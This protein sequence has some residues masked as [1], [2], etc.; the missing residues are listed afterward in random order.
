MPVLELRGVSKVVEGR[1]VLRGVDL[2]VGE[3]DVVLL[4]GPNGSGKTTLI[5]VAVGLLR[6]TS[7]A[8]LYRG[9]D[10]YSSASAN[11]EYR[12]RVGYASE[13][14]EYPYWLSVEEYLEFYAGLRGEDFGELRDRALELAE[15]LGFSKFWGYKVRELSHGNL[16]KLSLVRALLLGSELF[17]LDEPF[18]GLDEEGVSGLLRV[19]EGYA[20][21]GKAVV[22]S[23]HM[24][25]EG[26]KHSKLYLVRDGTVSLSA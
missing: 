17:V 11:W 24:L 16:R 14:E 21:S 7:G 1:S 4:K 26:L 6:P 13:R 19:I 2:S 10:V 25:P 20:K 5:R 22:V 9:R 3:G 23:G 8:V 12:R 18:V 15:E